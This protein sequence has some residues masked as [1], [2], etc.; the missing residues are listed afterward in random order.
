MSAVDVDSVT[1]RAGSTENDLA[2]LRK[3]A[4]QVV[5]SVFYGT[6][7]KT[8]RESELK[9]MYGHGGRGEEVFSAQLHGVWAEQMGTQTGGGLGEVLYRHLSKQQTLISGQAVPGPEI[10]R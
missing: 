6:L 3:A 9:G 2:R 10:Q 7:L 1:Q 8:M 5:G 4:G